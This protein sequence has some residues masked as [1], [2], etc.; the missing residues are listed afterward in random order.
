MLMESNGKC[1]LTNQVQSLKHP[2]PDTGHPII[3]E[4]YRSSVSS[5]LGAGG[6]GIGGVEWGIY[7][8]FRACLNYPGKAAH[9]NSLRIASLS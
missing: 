4:V 7:L 2:D 9:R 3:S 5:C 8:I 6:G 1:H